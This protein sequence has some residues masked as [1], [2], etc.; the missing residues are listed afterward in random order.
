MP[1]LPE[2]ETVRRGLADKLVQARI[3]T[4]RVSL[5][6]QV[7]RPQGDARAFSQGLCGRTIQAIDRRGKYLVFTLSGGHWLVA[8]LGMSGRLLVKSSQALPAAHTHIILTFD[9][10]LALHYQDVRQFG[11]LALWTADPYLQAPLAKLGPEPLSDDFTA[12]G[13]YQ[14]S[15]GRKLAVKS[16]ILDQKI[17]A[18]VG[19]IYADEALFRA[20]LRP[21]KAAGR[22]SRKDCQGLHRAICQ[23]LEEGI[24]AGG[25]SIRDYVG[26]DGHTG[27]YQLTHRVYGRKGQ[28]CLVCGRPL[29]S[30][31]VGGRSSV[32]CPHCQSS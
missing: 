27:G 3:E 15:R 7:K 22:L 32:Y 6:K 2:V 11:G 1:E 5:P 25:S 30:I 29:K 18:G 28:A 19:N 16:F 23:V 17:I 13:L 4:V 12:E 9:R 8:H 24:A 26:A 14:K 10:G 20:G 31:I 21:R